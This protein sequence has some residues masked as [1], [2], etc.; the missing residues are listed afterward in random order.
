MP[1][2]ATND[3]CD[4]A[5]PVARSDILTSPP[6]QRHL[7][8]TN[9]EFH[10]TKTD[11]NLP[12]L[13]IISSFGS[14]LG[15]S[16]SRCSGLDHA[17]L[18]LLE[19][20]HALNLHRALARVHAHHAL[21]QRA[22]PGLLAGA[23][24][25]KV[26]HTLVRAGVQGDDCALAVHH[27]SRAHRHRHRALRRHRHAHG[28]AGAGDAH[29]ADLGV[30]VHLNVTTPGEQVGIAI[31]GVDAD[32]APLRL[33]VGLMA[34]A[35]QRADVHSR[36]TCV[37]HDVLRV[38]G[39][40]PEGRVMQLDLHALANQAL[41]VDGAP[42]RAQLHVAAAQLV[43]AQRAAPGRAH[44]VHVR[45]IC[46]HRAQL[47]VAAVRAHR[48]AGLHHLGHVHGGTALALNVVADPLLRCCHL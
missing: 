12:S 23:V 13:V 26:C 27:A 46:A 10:R 1:P 4:P 2:P 38:Q 19:P 6:L 15:P 36:P 5:L 25:C 45:R 28:A 29:A 14:H 32:L 42:P 44:G 34:T 30:K 16:P 39:A 11:Q 22:V 18:D 8:F 31:Q 20:A 7:P 35:V 48:E 40:H 9:Q 3:S 17:L 43:A 47:H 21:A 41:E 24:G 33:D 37:H